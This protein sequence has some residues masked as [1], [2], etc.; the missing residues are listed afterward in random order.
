M[1]P[2]WY[3]WENYLKM[4]TGSLYIISRGSRA[5]SL[6]NSDKVFQRPPAVVAGL[7][8]SPWVISYSAERKL[9]QNIVHL[10]GSTSTK[11]HFVGVWHKCVQVRLCRWGLWVLMAGQRYH[12]PCLWK[13][14]GE[15]HIGGT[16][17]EVPSRLVCGPVGWWML[18]I[19]SAATRGLT[20]YNSSQWY[21]STRYCKFQL[22]KHSVTCCWPPQDSYLWIVSVGFSTTQDN[23][24]CPLGITPTVWKGCYPVGSGI[25]FTA[26]GCGCMSWGTSLGLG[27][28]NPT[29]MY[30][31]A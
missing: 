21:S 17:I 2:V 31:D 8:E 13:S 12:F 26:L 5:I 1:Y 9:L 20:C 25:I 29:H 14:C 7:V 6:Q 24:W 19:P 18:Q 28:T 22:C 27:S 23:P 11:E 4:G 15:V 10:K 16:S 30:P 3:L